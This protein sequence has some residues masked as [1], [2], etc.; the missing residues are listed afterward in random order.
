[1][2]NKDSLIRDLVIAN[3]I[4]AHEGVVDSYGHV[5]VRL[6]DNPDRFLL[7]RSRSPEQVTAEDILVFDLNGEP[8]EKTDDALYSERVIHARIFAAR[9]DVQAVVHGHA[10]DVLPF[11]VTDVKLEPVLHVAGII[12]HKLPVWDMTDK[13]GD[14]DLLVT[15]NEHADDLASTLADQRVVLMRGHGFT[16]TGPSLE[17][18]VR[19]SYYLKV[20]AR[21]QLD[22]LRLGPV[23]ALSAGEIDQVLARMGSPRATP[24]VWA[25]WA[26]RCG[27]GHLIN[28]DR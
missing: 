8:I 19:T 26:V 21:L 14:T 18:A 11:T 13:F 1:M 17:L 7:S 5:S 20:N 4:L 22:A 28:G 23:K 6:P 3:R 9:P 2:A 27:V 12:G 15:S 24:R 10:Q 16:A 25:N